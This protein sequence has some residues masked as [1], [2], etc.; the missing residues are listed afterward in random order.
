MGFEVNTLVKQLIYPP[1]PHYSLSTKL[2]HARSISPH[3]F[4]SGKAITAILSH[5]ARF[6]KIHVALDVWDWMGQS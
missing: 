4:D 1:P 2:A 5:L 6:K 3:S